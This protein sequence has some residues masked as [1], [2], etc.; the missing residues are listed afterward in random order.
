MPV[1]VA[2][3]AENVATDVPAT[4]PAVNATVRPL[5]NPLALSVA[6]PVNPPKDVWVIVSVTA[7]PCETLTLVGEAEREKPGAVGPAKAAAKMTTLRFAGRVRLLTVLAE[8]RA[9]EYA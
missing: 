3:L 6:V 2:V 4:V 5:G 9:K 7:P 1:T 8:L